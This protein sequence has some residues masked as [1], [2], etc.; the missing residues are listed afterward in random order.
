M[1]HKKHHGGQ[2]KHGHMG[3]IHA[4][5]G[6]RHHRNHEKHDG[7]ASDEY[8]KHNKAHGMEGGVHYP[9]LN[10]EGDYSGGEGSGGGAPSASENEHCD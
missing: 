8:H 9:P 2:K 6:L 4:G 1:A 3:H 10:Y 5:H 7:H